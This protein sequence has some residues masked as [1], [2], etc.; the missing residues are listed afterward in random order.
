M[1][2]ERT[3]AKAETPT[4]CPPDAKNRYVRKDPDA[5]KAGRQEGKGMTDEEMVGWHH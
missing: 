3:D 5:G 2:I 1:F 4:L